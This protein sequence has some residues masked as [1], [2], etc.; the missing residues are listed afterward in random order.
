M[1][2][3]ILLV[4]LVAALAGGYMYLQKQ[5]AGN[6]QSNTITLYGNVDI[7]D[8]SLA[9]R[10]GGRLAAVHFDEGD[11]VTPG[12]LMAELDNVPFEESVALNAA[13]L[14]EA[15]AALRNAE[16][17]YSRKEKLVGSGAVSQ[18]AHDD[19]LALREEAQARVATAKA[20]LAQAVTALEDTR[21][22]APAGGTVL[23]R[24]REPGSI[25]PAGAPVFTL[26]LDSPVWVRA[27]VEEP[28]LGHVFPG[29]KATV[30]TDSGGRYQGQ[31]GFVSPQAEFTPKN[32]ETTQLRTDLVYRLRIVVATPDE[33]LRQGMPVT[34]QLLP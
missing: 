29:R 25:L 23:T 8:V 17:T 11:R 18:G 34:V 32:V 9:F 12:A 1:K 22:L 30:I 20:R 16:R 2:K 6:Q 27:Y 31:I 5:Q 24:G 26:A 15:E 3:L 21:L 33:G 4:L 28:L 7:R 19:S 10:V 14:A 13:A